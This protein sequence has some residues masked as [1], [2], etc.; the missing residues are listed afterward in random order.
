MRN[1]YRLLPVR[2]IVTRI[3][4]TVFFT[5][6]FCVLAY[7]THDAYLGCKAKNQQRDMEDAKIIATMP[8][9]WQDVC[10]AVQ[11]DGWLDSDSETL[12][13]AV[14]KNEYDLCWFKLTREQARF[15]ASRYGNGSSDY[16]QLMPYIKD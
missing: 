8:P 7:M 10:Y 16:I 2:L 1:H 9:K 6:M 4:L 13:W 12:C 3:I 14:K 5:L 11:N 15:I